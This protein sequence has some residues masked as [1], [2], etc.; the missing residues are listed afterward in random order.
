LQPG[1]TVCKVIEIISVCWGHIVVSSHEGIE[2]TQLIELDEQIVT[3]N[4]VESRKV[5]ASKDNSGDTKG[6]ELIH[7]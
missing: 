1:F 5:T 4:T 2:D 3:W 6:K 7:R